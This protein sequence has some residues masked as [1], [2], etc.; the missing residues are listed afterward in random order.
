MPSDP[1]YL[2]HRTWKKKLWIGLAIGAPPAIAAG[3]AL[4]ALLSPPPAAE[5]PP[6]EPSAADVAARTEIVPKDF[7]INQST[8]LQIVEVGVDRKAIP[9]HITGLLRNSTNMR[10]SGAEVTVDLTDAKGSQVG[11]AVARVDDIPPHTT[12]R[13]ATEIPQK[14]V[15]YVLVREV[16]SRY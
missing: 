4:Y 2:S 13:F 8:E 3:V 14:N 15:V 7:R 1:L 10:F 5:R 11:A 9:H 12:V 6:S 16:K